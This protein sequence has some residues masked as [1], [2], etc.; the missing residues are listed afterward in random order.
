MPFC[1]VL[2]ETK[3]QQLFKLNSFYNLI[4]IL[5]IKKEAILFDSLFL[6]IFIRVT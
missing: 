5:N 3:L 1:I 2:K 6:N 4:I